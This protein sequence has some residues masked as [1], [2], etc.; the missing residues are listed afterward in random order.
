[1]HAVIGTGPAG[2]ALV[3]ELRARGREVVALNRAGEAAVPEGVEVRAADVT[4][5]AAM[6]ALG[7]EAEVVYNCAHAPY[8]QWDELLPRMQEGF[9][10]AGENARLVVTDTLYMYGPTGGRPMTE[11]TPHAATTRKGR[12]RA[13]IAARYLDAHDAGVAEVA[14]ARAADFYGPRVTNSALGAAVFLPVLHGQPAFALGDIDL[15]HAYSHIEDVARTLATLGDQERALGRAWHVPT[16]SEFSTRQVHALI[17]DLVGHPVEANVLP[18]PTTQAW[19]P[20]DAG[21]M[22]EYAELFYQY[23]EPQVV[24]CTAVAEAFDLT[25]VPFVDGLKQTLDWYRA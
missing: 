12:I 18:G 23:L 8:H 19:G 5:V 6:R 17:A 9:L 15:P 14:I 24:D 16:V 7:R 25:P 4:D 10:A 3:D 13:A 22:S 21:F 1:M 2:L 11:Q 20:F